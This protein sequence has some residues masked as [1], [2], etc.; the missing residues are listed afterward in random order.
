M[1]SFP[2]PA[3]VDWQLFFQLNDMVSINGG[4]FESVGFR[5]LAKGY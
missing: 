5:R 2:N 4:S 1:W 3:F